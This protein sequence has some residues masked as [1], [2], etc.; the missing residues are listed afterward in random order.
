M[1]GKLKTWERGFTAGYGAAIASIARD[2]GE[3]DLAKL[4]LRECGMSLLDFEQSIPED[5][6]LAWIHR[7]S[8][9]AP[10]A[11]P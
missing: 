10:G 8:D 3:I 1:S 2:F 5:A 4:L 11:K 9:P 7:L 6:D